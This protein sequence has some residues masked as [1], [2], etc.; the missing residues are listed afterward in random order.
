MKNYLENLLQ[1]CES[2]L[3]KEVIE[4]A[5]DNDNYKNPIGYFKDVLQYGCAS[6]IVTELIYY[7]QTEEFFDRH[8]DEILEIYDTI[9]GQGIKL[10]MEINRNNLSWLAF[11]ETIRSIYDDYMVTI[12]ED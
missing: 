9:L 3:T 10:N 6:G 5:L 7:Y 1:D 4:I 12:E 2:E 8:V 11:E